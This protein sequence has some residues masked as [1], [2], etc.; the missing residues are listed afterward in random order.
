MSEDEG[1]GD[2]IIE[3][4]VCGIGRDRRVGGKA[5]QR[6]RSRRGQQD[7]R[8]IGG[9][10]PLGA[11]WH[12]G[13]LEKGDVE[14]DVV[15][16][17]NGRPIAKRE[18]CESDHGILAAGRSGE[19]LVR[20][21]GQPPDG[22]RQRP[23]GVGEREKTLTKLDRPIRPEP[24]ADGTDLDDPLAL[25]LVSGRLEVDCDELAFQR[26]ADLAAEQAVGHRAAC[27]L[28][29]RTAPTASRP[30]HRPCKQTAVSA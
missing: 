14:A 19:V 6:V 9:V 26:F 25:G 1:G 3:R 4:A 24:D 16:D 8:E 11:Q 30:W 18:A 13:P 21:A 15:S 23:L 28:R 10:E 2:R 5:L 27:A 20:Y 12:P 29:K 7:R 17:E 22:R